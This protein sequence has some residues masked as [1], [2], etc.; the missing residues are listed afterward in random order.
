MLG[1]RRQPK[2]LCRRRKEG[3]N[4]AL[5]LAIPPKEVQSFAIQRGDSRMSEQQ[6]DENASSKPDNAMSMDER[7][8]VLRKLGR[9]AAITPPAIALLLAAASKPAK[10]ISSPV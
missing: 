5:A 1:H 2:R 6:I 7:R 8:R 4:P 3:N 10:A 9:F